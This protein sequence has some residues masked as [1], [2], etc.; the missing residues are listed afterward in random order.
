MSYYDNNK[1]LIGLR[2]K[3]QDLVDEKASYGY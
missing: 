2:N 1:G 3:R